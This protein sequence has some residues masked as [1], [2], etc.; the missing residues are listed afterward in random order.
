MKRW[1][2]IAASLAAALAAFLG[3]NYWVRYTPEALARVIVRAELNDPE[4]AVFR[5]ERVSPKRTTNNYTVV[6]GEVNSRNRLG[7]MVGF[8]RYVAEVWTVPMF[9]LVVYGALEWPTPTM[10]TVRINGDVLSGDITFWW[11]IY[12]R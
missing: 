4:S 8:T 5:S 1:G 2:L 7:G 10:G 6:C 12:C 11:D 9:D 3:V